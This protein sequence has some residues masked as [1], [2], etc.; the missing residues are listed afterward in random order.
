MNGVRRLIEQV[1]DEHGTRRFIQN[2]ADGGSKPP[3]SMGSEPSSN[4]ELRANFCRKVGYFFV[5]FSNANVEAR[6]P[7]VLAVE[8]F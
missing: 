5:G 3:L 1:H 6:S 7:V 4:N 8:G 2:S